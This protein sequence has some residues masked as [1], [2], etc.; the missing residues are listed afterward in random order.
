MVSAS[1]KFLNIAKTVFFKLEKYD[2]TKK[3]LIYSIINRK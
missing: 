2:F 1:T 3:F